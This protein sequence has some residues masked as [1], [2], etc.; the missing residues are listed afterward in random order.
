MNGAIISISIV[1]DD[2]TE[3]IHEIDCH[4]LVFNEEIKALVTVIDGK[5]IE[6]SL[7]DFIK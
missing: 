7:R 5:E 1:L 6:I 3:T 4:E 2:K